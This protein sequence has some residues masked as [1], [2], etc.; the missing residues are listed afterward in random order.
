MKS[1]WCRS[2]LSDTSMLKL[3]TATGYIYGYVQDL[4]TGMWQYIMLD[5]ETGETVFTNGCF[6]QA[7][8]QQYGHRHVC[9][10]QRKCPLLS[11]RI[12]G[13][14]KTSGPF[15]LLA[16]NAVPQSGS[17]SGNAKCAWSRK[18]LKR[19]ADREMLWAG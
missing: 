10:K 12:S 14:V 5:F 15:C 9:R 4:E 7:W 16:G 19:M 13:A 3:S 11:D 17:G 18:P 8:L 1:I 2:D 6:Q